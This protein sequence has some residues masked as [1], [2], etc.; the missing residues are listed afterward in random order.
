MPN[1]ITAV[2]ILL[3]IS[4]IMT[5]ITAVGIMTLIKVLRLFKDDANLQIKAA[6]KIIMA[7]FTGSAT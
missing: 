3:L 2:L 5:E 1:T 6:E 4:R 7:T